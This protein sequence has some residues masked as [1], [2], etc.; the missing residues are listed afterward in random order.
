MLGSYEGMTL[1]RTAG[2]A[3]GW[4]DATT[5]YF[6]EETFLPKLELNYSF[7]QIKLIVL[8]FNFFYRV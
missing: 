6:Q 4:T 5:I 8:N 2:I 7:S 3:R 1:L